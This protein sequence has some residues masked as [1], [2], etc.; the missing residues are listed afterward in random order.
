M[1]VLC[2]NKYTYLYDLPLVESRCESVMVLL[3]MYLA[4][5]FEGGGWQYCLGIITYYLQLTSGMENEW[6]YTVSI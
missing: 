4:Y 3:S 6:T 2:W 5:G 1:G